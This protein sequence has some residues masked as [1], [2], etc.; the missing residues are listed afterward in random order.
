MNT[1]NITTGEKSYMRY[2]KRGWTRKDDFKISGYVYNRI[3]E[4]VIK[5]WGKFTENFYI[6]RL[7]VEGAE[8][9]KVWEMNPFPDNYH[10]QYY[11]SNYCLQVNYLPESL[12]KKIPHTDCRFRTDQRALENGDL[13]TA[14]FE[15]NRIEEKQRA[16]RKRDQD[17]KKIHKPVYFDEYHDEHASSN[18]KAY[19]FNGKY[20]IDRENGDWSHLPDLFGKD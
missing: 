8:P 17:I 5:M 7:D 1:I 3:G 4:K 9:I 12:E 6:Q 10:M 20:W 13:K 11:F 15:K 2:T 14:A 18:E 19:R 16:A